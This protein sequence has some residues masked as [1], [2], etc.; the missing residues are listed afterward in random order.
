MT[1]ETVS[2][3][4]K[5]PALSVII[6]V[7]N[8]ERFLKETIE[9]ICVQPKVELIEVI[10]IDDGS[11]DHSR[12][13]ALA[14]VEKHSLNYQLLTQSNSGVG[15][16]RNA[17]IKHASGEYICFLDQD[18]VWV[19]GFFNDAVLDVL[20]TEPDMVSFS[21]YEGN[22]DL[23]RF[24]LID[25]EDGLVLDPW[26][27]RGKNYRH[28]SSYLFKRSFVIQ[29]DLFVDGF[30]HEDERYRLCCLSKAKSLKY[31]SSPIFIYRNNSGSVTHQTSSDLDSVYR[32]CLNGWKDLSEKTE[33]ERLVSDARGTMLHLLIEW[34]EACC[35]RREFDQWYK[36]VFEEFNGVQLYEE[37]GWISKKDSQAWT[38]LFK[39]SLLFQTRYGIEAK[40]N[41]ALR[42]IIKA[43]CL[44][45]AVD[46]IKYPI[47]FLS[48]Q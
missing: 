1:T 18:D 11:T 20:K 41:H 19:E 43:P 32:S 8:G 40:I 10:L 26:G 29:N 37:R 47:G 25:R 33:D 24:R 17:G 5:N 27:D 35:M 38:L 3:E 34:F 46:R 30:R 2:E 14:V 44:Q 6:P 22:Q 28:H 31:V 48:G 7:Y 13:E 4:K 39:N 23:T 42:R 16:A 36:Q 45:K 9:S 15:A 21:Y 12:E